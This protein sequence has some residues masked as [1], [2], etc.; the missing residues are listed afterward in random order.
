MELSQNP[1]TYRKLIDSV[2]DVVR[3]EAENYDCLQGLESL[4]KQQKIQPLT[5][6]EDD[7]PFEDDEDLR[8]LKGKKGKWV[9]SILNNLGGGRG[10]DMPKNGLAMATDGQ[11]MVNF[12]L[13]RV[14]YN[15]QQQEYNSTVAAASI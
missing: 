14:G 12:N 2:L 8:F 15:Q 10:F 4:K 5:S 11:Q 6:E 7:D 9:N 1:E 13:N 3:K